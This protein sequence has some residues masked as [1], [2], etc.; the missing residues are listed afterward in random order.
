ME[1]M[2]LIR[3]CDYPVVKE[4]ITKDF[5]CILEIYER[6][7]EGTGVSISIV[8]K[9]IEQHFTQ[10]DFSI[11]NLA[12]D[13]GVSTAY[14]SYLYKKEKNINLSESIWELRKNKAIEYLVNTDLTIEEISNRIGYD[15]VTSF[16]RKF[17]ADTGMT[18]SQFKKQ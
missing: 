8:Q 13:M 14:L 5:Y 16:R 1:M 11:S 18:P 17:K 9:Y 3:S 6:E 4:S 7:A 12:I 10:S 15:N 2:Y